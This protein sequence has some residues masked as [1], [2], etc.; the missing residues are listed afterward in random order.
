MTYSLQLYKKLDSVRSSSL[1]T[2]LLSSIIYS[3]GNF[4]HLDTHFLLKAIFGAS[5]VG[6]CS[7]A[8]FKLKFVA[9]MTLVFYLFFLFIL[10]KLPYDGGSLGFLAFLSVATVYI[11]ERFLPSRYSH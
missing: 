3:L 6:M 5:F 9:L 8:K 1:T 10:E 7:P 2:L 11:I 4:T